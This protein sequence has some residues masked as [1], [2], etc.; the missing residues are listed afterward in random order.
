MIVSQIVASSKNGVIGNQNDLP[1]DIPED[2]EFFRNKTKKSVMIMGRKTFETLGKPLPGRYHIIM[3]SQ[4]DYTTN[5]KNTYV[6][7]SYNEA[8]TCAQEVHKKYEN[9]EVFVIG[10]GQVY[11]ETL[12][13]VDRVYLTIISK[14]FDGDAYFPIEEVDTYHNLVESKMGLTKSP[15]LEFRTYEK[16]SE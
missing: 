3:T 14:D 2:M 6:V 13:Q 5:E 12:D 1:W 7:S 10:G 11:K 9:K 8:L 16:K 15:E 4:P